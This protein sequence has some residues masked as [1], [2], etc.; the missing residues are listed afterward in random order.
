MTGWTD[1]HC[2]LNDTEAFAD[3]A[4]AV[5]EANENGV[6][7]LIVVGVDGESSRLAL[8]ISE[9]FDNVWAVV[10]WHPNSAASFSTDGL[11]EISA[12]AGH[13]K[14]VAIGEIGLDFHWSYATLEQ[15]K[16]A[17]F[18]QLDLAAELG[19]PVVFH[20]R[21]A[22]PELLD[23]LEARPSHPYLMHCFAGGPEDA[24][25]A[26]ALGCLFGVDGPV[27]YKKADDLRATLRHIGLQHLVL[28]T[29]APWMAP[30][31]H[32]GKRNKPAW[33]A[34]VGQGLAV[35]LEIDPEEIKRV[36]N[37]NASRFFGI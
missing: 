1:T 9:Q 14:A 12:A 32:R 6:D 35:A 3:P 18:A 19:K 5:R 11:K 33:T 21:E 37:A 36:T 27:T 13:P 23:I 25:R 15:Q 26:L 29:D 8:E 17:L 16:S 31:P 2:H 7:R 34:L 4:E 20:C 24:D 28:E 22:Y 10:G 30:H